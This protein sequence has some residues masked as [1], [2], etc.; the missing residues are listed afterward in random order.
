MEAQC[1][2]RLEFE[3]MG[4]GA[5]F[6]ALLAA[7]V[8]DAIEIVKHVASALSGCGSPIVIQSIRPLTTVGGSHSVLSGSFLS[9]FILTDDIQHEFLA[10]YRMVFN[11]KIDVHRF[12]LLISAS[13]LLIKYI[14]CTLQ[15]EQK[16]K[17][18]AQTFA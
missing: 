12:L 9:V 18:S 1:I 14:R 16:R 15:K 17:L 4:H 13:K 11:V 2:G 10:K 8:V 3:A 6:G 5:P 7:I